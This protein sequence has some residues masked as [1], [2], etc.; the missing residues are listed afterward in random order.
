[1]KKKILLTMCIL[2]LSAITATV[3]L[4]DSAQEDFLKDMA[5]GLKARWTY[6][7]DENAMSR[8]EFTE[9]R[10]TLVKEEYD[11]LIKYADAEFENEKFNLMAQAYMEAV[12]IQL[13][14]L[15]YCIELP[16]LY[17]VEW[18]AG[19][20]IRAMLVPEF[21]D[22]YSL[23]VPEEEVA[24]FRGYNDIT[25][26]AETEETSVE[27]EEIVVYDDEGIRVII[28]GM[29][30]LN[31]GGMSLRVRVE[32][33]NH[34][35]IIVA[36]KD[37]KV[38]VNGNMM[39][40]TIFAEVQSGKTANTSID[41]YQN[42]LDNNGIDEIKDISFGIMI[43]DAETY[44]ELYMGDEKFLVVNEGYKISE[45]EVYTD[46]DSIQKVQ[47]LLNQAGYDCGSAD[48]VPGKKTNNALLEFERDHGLSETTD[49]T[50]ELIDAI[51]SAIN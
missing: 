33:L 21:V 3:A 16:G 14:A 34:H 24:K 44:R 22:Y 2:A 42:E 30:E 50:P 26:M 25:Y 23:D 29:N 13:D 46:K 32:N 48:G 8:S 27:T 31:I 37:H 45:K 38:V 41:F 35:D 47:T 40:S 20:N 28:T 36:T 4:A 18:A 51:E 17:E 12:E 39:N 6:D 11:R 19:Y 10:T 9:Y 7:S 5:D 1:M 49:I 15:K 43:L